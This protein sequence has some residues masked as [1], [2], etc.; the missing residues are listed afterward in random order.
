[1]KCDNCKRNKT[2]LYPMTIYGKFRMWCKWCVEKSRKKKDQNR[3]D[4]RGFRNEKKVS[5]DRT[6]KA[7]PEVG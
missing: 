2:T 1:M 7:S 4:E 3:R 5:T 6:P